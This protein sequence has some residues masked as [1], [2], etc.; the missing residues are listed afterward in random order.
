[1]VFRT[2][3]FNISGVDSEIMTLDGEQLGIILTIILF[4]FMFYVGYYSPKR[5]GGLFLLFSGFLFLSLDFTLTSYMSAVFVIPWVTIIALFII[6]LGIKK[7]FFP[8]KAVTEK[9]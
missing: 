3:N 5:S 6:V 2:E 4:M 8:K 7:Y 1:L 9:T